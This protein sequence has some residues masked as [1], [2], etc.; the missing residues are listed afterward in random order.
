MQR[1]SLSMDFCASMTAMCLVCHRVKKTNIN[2]EYFAEDLL[3]EIQKQFQRASDLAGNY[4]PFKTMLA[5]PIAISQGFKAYKTCIEKHAIN[6]ITKRKSPNGEKMMEVFMDLPSAFNGFLVKFSDNSMLALQSLSTNME[7]LITNFERIRILLLN[8]KKMSIFLE[9]STIK[10]VVLA[11]NYYMV[12]KST[13][14]LSESKSSRKR[15]I[16]LSNKQKS[17]LGDKVVDM[18]LQASFV[19]ESSNLEDVKELL[20]SGLDSATKR[21]NETSDEVD[22]YSWCDTGMDDENFE[23]NE[24][25]NEAAA[26]GFFSESGCSQFNYLRSNSSVDDALIK[27]KKSRRNFSQETKDFV[28]NAVSSVKDSIR[29]YNV[30]SSPPISER[31]LHRQAIQQ[32]IKLLKCETGF[33]DLEYRNVYNW[34]INSFNV[35]RKL[36]RCVNSDFENDVWGNLIVCIV[37]KS[38]VK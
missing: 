1:A 10:D 11:Y 12:Q 6:V 29:N 28:L 18:L 38:L 21:A 25:D 19:H 34:T 31:L 26:S 14:I 35:S 15:I 3:S 27:C 5:V 4:L 22:E 36:G 17:N 7:D 30:N 8:S 9:Q 13:S 33:Y 20:S 24:E 37:E 32:T 2:I 16:E 23:L